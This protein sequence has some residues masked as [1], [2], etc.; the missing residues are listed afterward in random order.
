MDLLQSM[1]VF[2]CVV[3]EGGFAA[4]ARKMG[5]APA[6]VTRQIQELEHSLRVRL[7][8]RTT[9]KMSLTLAGEGYLSRLRPILSEIDE[10][11]DQARAHSSEIS[12]SLRVATTSLVAVNLLAQCVAE[13]QGR[14]PEVQ[15]EIHTSDRP[16]QELHQFDLS[17]VRQDDHLDA[18]VVVR[19]V[20]DMN[21][22]LCG[23]SSYLHAHGVPA[24]P[25]D[26][27]QHRMVR[28]RTPGTRL[29]A[30]VLVNPAEGGRGVEIL[31]ASS[32]I[33]NDDE[34]A[35]QAALAGAGLTLLP[36]LA[37]TARSHGGQLKR[38]LAPWVSADG[39]RLVATLPSR[40][41]LPLRTRSFLEFFVAHVQK[42]AAIAETAQPS[43]E[44][45]G[46]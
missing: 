1:R 32:V 45:S 6:V 42:V 8:H 44:L 20:L 37:L 31:P 7:L 36:E 18:D 21:Y 29:Q 9:R 17:I 10:A 43:T 3:D 12:G 35:Y 5:L 30:I 14:H 15:V 25:E 19:P 16:G 46:A 11:A 26:L 2:Q 41:F 23:A 13:F 24:A 40:R 22:V 27:L 33:S 4:A 34:T 28:L 38:V 39:L